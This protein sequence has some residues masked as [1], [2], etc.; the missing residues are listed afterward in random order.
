MLI[1]ALRAAGHDP[2]F[3]VGGQLAD[4]GTNAHL[5]DRELFVLEADEAFGTFLS[6]HLAGLMVTNVE[7][8]HMDYYVTRYRLDDAFAHVM[9][10]VA[11]PVLACA[12]DPGA[13][14]LAERTGA[15]TYGLS[16][17]ADWQ[18]NGLE[19][20]GAEEI[21]F[22]LE[23]NTV[24]VDVRV[25]RPGT[26]M[27]LNAAGA[28]AL[29][30]EL[31]HD[32]AEAASG[33]AEFRGVRRR[34]ETRGTVAGVTIID[35]YAHHPTEVAATIRAARRGRW[36]AIWAVFQPHL[37]SRT[38]AMYSEFGQS[39]A[40]ADQVVITDVFGARE[41]PQPGITGELIADAAMARTD[42][43]VSYVPH[44]ADL[45]EFLAGRVEE[46][47]LVLTMGAGDITLLPD[48]LSRLLAART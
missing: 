17:G 43:K 8:E 27:A 37:Y 48:E 15:S 38:A 46:G 10:G 19:E 9:R 14:R 31:G 12:D 40:G 5:G 20:R 28:I 44:R 1:A 33:L 3:V 30:A 32:P 6:L 39:F 34:F 23:S 7:E 13:R 24:S 16:D 11:G 18:I 25:G 45:A 21:A 22:T 4:L 47:D 36:R 29:L 35:D 2:S 41:A 26:H 42:A